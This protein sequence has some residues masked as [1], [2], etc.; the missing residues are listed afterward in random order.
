[1]DEL[2]ILKTTTTSIVNVGTSN[3]LTFIDISMSN[4]SR[5]YLKLFHSTL[6]IRIKRFSGK[7]Y[8]KIFQTYF[9]AILKFDTQK[10]WMQIFHSDA[11][12]FIV[13]TKFEDG[14]INDH[15]KLPVLKRFEVKICVKIV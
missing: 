12:F 10:C 9:G 6:F 7:T 15:R 8:A 13:A 11:N 3:L 4:L 1:M 2:H 14:K 5:V